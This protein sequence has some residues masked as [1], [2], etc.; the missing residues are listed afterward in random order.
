MTQPYDLAAA[1]ITALGC[2]TLSTPLDLRAL[3]DTDKSLPGHAQRGTLHQLWQWI[4]GYNQQ[5]YGIF[6]TP[7]ALDGQ[8][9][10]LEN[11]Q[12]IRAFYVDLDNQSAEQNLQAASRHA[13]APWFCVTSSPGK[14]HV[15][16]PVQHHPADIERFSGTQRR[17][18]QLY[19]GDRAVIDAARVMRLPGTLNHKYDTGH[20]VTCHALAGYGQPL[21]VDQ[22]E[23]SVSHVT[24]IDG[25]A[26]ERHELGDPEL[27]AP[28]LAW[29][30]RALD[31]VDPNDLDRAEWIAMTAAVKQA[32]WTLVDESQLMAIWLAWCAR[33]E[34]DDVGENVKQW[35]SL[36][37]TELG[38]PSLLRRVPS[39][40]AAML[41]GAA[42]QTVAPPAPSAP[43]VPPMPT[44]TGEPAPLDCSGEFLTHL[45][46][47]QWFKGCVFVSSMGK[48][49]L[50]NGR[51]LNQT[52]FN[53]GDHAGK[54][55]IITQDGKTTDE[56]WKAA[57]RST[58][59]TIPKVD[60]L[61]FLPERGPSEI[62]VDVLG[63]R[64]V[65]TYVRPNIDIA[66]GD[67]SPF[68]NHLSRIIPDP[69]D[70]RI[71]LETHAVARLCEAESRPVLDELAAVWLIPP[72]ERAQAFLAVDRL[73]EAFH[74]ML[75][76]ATGNAEMARVHADITERIRIIRRL[77]FTKPQRVEAT[78]DEHA[79]LLR[80]ITRRRADEAQRMLRAHIEHSKL[81]VRRI[82]IETLY[83]ARQRLAEVREQPT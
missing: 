53:G 19:D 6:M 16:W 56:P 2:D 71:L 68:L 57:L 48:I 73:D 17:L 58:L 59:W 75:V 42:G 4:T 43:G 83:H 26:G 25:G 38:W 34:R 49:M 31:M 63:R 46:C 72:A 18:R 74:A 37:R 81:E 10:S 45:E 33:Y 55:F 32:G 62:I 41:F 3:H 66:P 28:S 64:G 23:Q 82:T 5:G 80:A 79:A 11:V 60:H 29:L 22:I 13:P 12:T 30:T 54:K 9:R 7:A 15:Y 27:A 35:N 24:V 39:L 52:S 76:Q 67:V 50:P 69:N 65:N 51:L 61:R 70:L 14:A 8:G 36:R 1:F 47:E 40:K 20:L 21:T 44:S 78:Y 77:D